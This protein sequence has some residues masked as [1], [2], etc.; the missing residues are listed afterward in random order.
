MWTVR[1]IGQIAVATVMEAVHRL[2]DP[3]QSSN[4][5]AVGQGPWSGRPW[6]GLLFTSPSRWLFLH[7]C[8]ADLFGRRRPPE[9]VLALSILGAAAN[10]FSRLALFSLAGTRAGGF[11]LTRKA[12]G[13]WGLQPMLWSAE[14]SRRDIGAYG[15]RPQQINAA[16]PGLGVE[17]VLWLKSAVQ[18]VW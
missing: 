15:H 16:G 7:A 1:R 18:H 4:C 9:P 11:V 10:H 3:P 14:A 2:N 8:F 12:A 13:K 17:P 5:R 6:L